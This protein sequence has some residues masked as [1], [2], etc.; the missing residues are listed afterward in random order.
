MRYQ[1]PWDKVKKKN[2]KNYR[3]NITDLPGPS[4]SEKRKSPKTESDGGEWL[5][6]YAPQGANRNTSS[7]L[8]RKNN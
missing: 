3:S 1:S 6:P 7:H 8:K 4:L 5:R 2:R